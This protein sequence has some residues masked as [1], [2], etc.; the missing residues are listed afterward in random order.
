MKVLKSKIFLTLADNFAT[1][2][3]EKGRSILSKETQFHPK[4]T[5][6]VGGLIDPKE[7]QFLRKDHKSI[8]LQ[9]LLVKIHD[10]NPQNGEYKHVTRI[11]D[12]MTQ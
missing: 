7:T 6:F 3:H 11:G 10:V 5:Q 2:H 1:I 4:E 8:V 12:Q 9:A